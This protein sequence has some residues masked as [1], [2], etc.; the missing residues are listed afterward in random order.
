M[1]NEKRTQYITEKNKQA[2]I[3]HMQLDD[4]TNRHINQELI[5]WTKKITRNER[6]SM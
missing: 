1:S 2:W 5:D 3:K 6:S 4:E